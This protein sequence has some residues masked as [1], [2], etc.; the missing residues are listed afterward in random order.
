LRVP[1]FHPQTQ[2]LTINQN[3]TSS[4]RYYILFFSLPIICIKLWDWAQYKRFFTSTYFSCEHKRFITKS[5]IHFIAAAIIINHCTSP[6][7]H[8][9][10][11]QLPSHRN[12]SPHP[13]PTTPSPKSHQQ[14]FATIN[15]LRPTWTGEHSRHTI[16]ITI[17]QY[18]DFLYYKNQ[19]R[20]L[21][22]FW[23]GLEQFKASTDLSCNT[24]NCYDNTA[25][26]WDC[27]GFFCQWSRPSWSKH[28]HSVST[29]LAR[30]P[31]F[32]I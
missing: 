30:F 19:P 22:K 4:F 29:L 23:D 31:P 1:V 32:K 16:T 27:Y 24:Y 12:P 2:S 7:H 9:L 5:I 26:V 28:L 13:N 18:D 21:V 14:A 10:L 11:K 25:C 20:S 15:D 3:C 8:L 6:N 17:R